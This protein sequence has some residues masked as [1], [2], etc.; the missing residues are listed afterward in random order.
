MLMRT[1]PRACHSCTVSALGLT[2]FARNPSQLR[3]PTACPGARLAPAQNACAASYTSFVTDR[4]E[5][6]RGWLVLV[7]K[8]P[9]EPTRL[10]ASVWRR[11]KAAG[12]VVLA[13]REDLEAFAASVYVVADHGSASPASSGP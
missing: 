10:R 4:G 8:L 7:Y 3:L 9:A 11:L 5:E 12:S 13:C 6:R 2:R 1:F